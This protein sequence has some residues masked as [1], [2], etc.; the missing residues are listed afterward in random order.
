[1]TTVVV[2]GTFDGLHPGHEDLFRQAHEYGE[3]L[4]VIVGRDET[5]KMVKGRLPRQSE[6]ER[7]MAVKVHPL[8]QDARL[9]GLGDKLATIVEVNPDVLVLGYDQQAFTDGIEA[10]LAAQ[11]AHPK[12]VRATA[13]HPER[14]K[15]SK[16]YENG[17]RE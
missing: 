10:K 8:V 7:L 14:Y 9:G 13:F 4:V 12:I 11:G 15:S 6:N 3:H 16:L 5:V 1:M 2:T 17:G